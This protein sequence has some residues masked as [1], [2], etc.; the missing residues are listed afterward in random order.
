MSPADTSTAWR[1]SSGRPNPESPR[2]TAAAGAGTV[3]LA[4]RHLTGR[5]DG[6]CMT[7]NLTVAGLLAEGVARLR[8]PGVGTAPAATADVDAQLLL[9][10]VL[11]VPRVRLK[12]HPEDLP[13]PARTQH[14]RR[15][16]ARRA[17]GAILDYL[18]GRRALC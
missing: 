15:L 1:Q 13:D 3:C 7:A 4:S 14:Y 12:S 2:Q 6:A 8:L 5:S 11:A 16:L 10:H 9:A 18:T 17:D